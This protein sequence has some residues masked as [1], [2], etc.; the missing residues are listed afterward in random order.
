MSIKT[1]LLYVFDFLGGLIRG[2][3]SIFKKG[4]R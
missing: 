2:I 4:Q 1:T 3:P